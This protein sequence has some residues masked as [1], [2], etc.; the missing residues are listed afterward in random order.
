MAALSRIGLAVSIVLLGACG[1]S[2]PQ[3]SVPEGRRIIA[4]P[5]GRNVSFGAF[6]DALE[7]AKVVYVGEHHD[8]EA[9]HHAQLAVLESLYARDPSLALGLEMVQHPFQA[10]LDA[11]VA[12]DIDE[13]TL[14]SRIDWRERWGF[15]W[16]LYRPMFWFAREHHLPIVALN[17]PVEL[18]RAVVRQGLDALD[19]AQRAALPEL[20]LTNTA[21]RAMVED[22]LHDHPGLD[23][24]QLDRFYAAQVVW[25]ETMAD[26]AAR[27]LARRGAPDRMLVLA[28][29]MH[30]RAGLGIPSR[31]AR[32]GAAPY[33]IVM[34]VAESELDEAL[35]ESPPVAD[36]L[37]V[38]PDSAGRDGDRFRRSVMPSSRSSIRVSAA[39][40]RTS[41]RRHGSTSERSARRLLRARN[42]ERSSERA[43]Q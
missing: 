28:G 42:R 41:G 38:T 33:V 3:P 34:P 30:V 6:A 15:G 43:Y 35:R 27:F 22:A 19:P 1:G 21:H 37:W 2:A 25:D 18:S 32:R 12:G 24:T 29:T 17:A 14:L 13:D 10:A 36:F 9:D 40:G 31:A 11:F 7:A 8:R 20:D 16:P 23:A 5:S 4:L 26:R 39:S